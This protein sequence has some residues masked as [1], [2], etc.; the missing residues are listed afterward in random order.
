MF[1]MSRLI[2]FNKPYG[3]ITQFS[4]DG[5]HATL[6]EFIPCPAFIRRDAWTPTAK[7]CS[8]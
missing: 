3:V 2:L 1:S 5:K 6:K 8:F 4:S 7:G